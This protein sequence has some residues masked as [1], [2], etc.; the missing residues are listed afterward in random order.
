ME[1]NV[2][3]RKHILKCNMSRMVHDRHEYTTIVHL[4]SIIGSLANA[5]KDVL[6]FLLRRQ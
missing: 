6:A 4:A 1:G 2:G 3:R 5:G